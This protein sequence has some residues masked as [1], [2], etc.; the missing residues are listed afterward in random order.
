MLSSLFVN[1]TILISFIFIAGQGIKA[2]PDVLKSRK[3]VI[4]AGIL[5]G[6]LGI[7][8][9]L[10]GLPMYDETLIDFRYIPVVLLAFYGEA[11]STFI[12]AA[13]IAVFRI[14]YY[15][16]NPSSVLGF[17]IVIVIAIGCVIISLAKLRD[18]K[19]FCVMSLYSLA[20][21]N[22]ALTILLSRH[23]KYALIIITY[24]ILYTFMTYIVY[25]LANYILESNRLYIKFKEQ[26]RKDFL[27]GLSNV[28]QY[29]ALLNRAYKRVDDLGEKLSILA[30]DID[31]FKRINDTHGH[32]GGD[33]VLKQLGEVLE[34]CCEPGDIAARVGGEEFSVILLDC[35]NAKAVEK[36]ENI[37]KAVN[38]TN[39]LLPDGTSINISISIGAATYPDSIDDLEKLKKQADIELYKAKETGRNKVCSRYVKGCS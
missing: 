13:I 17:A 27:T 3:G 8:L 37:R 23:G 15:P 35:S 31:H 1:S 6:I 34:S 29:D 26:A 4:A 2:N 10:Y 9:I 21:I 5:G 7:I 38:S 30:I 33:A 39:F 22:A 12:A 24:S 16:I 19:K 20:V 11:R 36:A 25:K 18:V 28:R 32:D 14:I